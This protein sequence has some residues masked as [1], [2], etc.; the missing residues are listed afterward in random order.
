MMLSDQMPAPA[1]GVVIGD[2]SPLIPLGVSV[3]IVDSVT[4]PGL[5]VRVLLLRASS[6]DTTTGFPVVV[7]TKPDTYSLARAWAFTLSGNSTD[8]VVSPFL[9]I[10]KGIMGVVF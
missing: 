6:V 8:K 10:L 5:G 7:D 2:P 3:A 1:P 4:E 9:T